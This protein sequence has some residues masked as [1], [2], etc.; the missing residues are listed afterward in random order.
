MSWRVGSEVGENLAGHKFSMGTRAN[1]IFTT[2]YSPTEDECDRRYIPPIRNSELQEEVLLS[3][4]DDVVL[5]GICFG[6]SQGV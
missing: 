4:V 1:G 2:N 3:Q 5:R 6:K